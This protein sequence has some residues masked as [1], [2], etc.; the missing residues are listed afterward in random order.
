MK[1]LLDIALKK[2][3]G[4]LGPCFSCYPIINKLYS[5]FDFNNDVFILSKGHAALAYYAILNKYGFLDDNEFEMVYENGSRLYGHV[6]RCPEI[7]ITAT[8][9]SLGHGA[10]IAAGIALAGREKKVFCLLGDGELDEGSVWEA[11]AFCTRNKLVNINFIID[12]NE[13]QGYDKLLETESL[14]TKIAGFGVESIYSTVDSLIEKISWSE[15]V[16]ANKPKCFIVR[17]DKTGGFKC[18]NGMSAHY[19]KMDQELYDEILSEIENE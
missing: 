18:L 5:T 15:R 17:T 7:G 10:S 2:K 11:F 4:H 14:G 12:N 1:K 3:A 9:G 13:Y 16:F 6:S 8:A 19:R